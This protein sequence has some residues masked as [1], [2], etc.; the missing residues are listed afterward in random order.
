ME[1]PNPSASSAAYLKQATARLHR[2]V[3]TTLDPAAACRSEAAFV[4]MVDHLAAV[5][6]RT[7]ADARARLDGAGIDWLDRSE[8]RLSA[9]TG[10]AEDRTS[11]RDSSR[12][13]YRSLER[14]EPAAVGS[15]YVLVGSTLGG[16]QL[17]RMAQ[18]SFGHVPMEAF[19]RPDPA[20][21]AFQP[22]MWPEFTAWIDAQGWTRTELARAARGARQTFLAFHPTT[23]SA[24]ESRPQ[25]ASGTHS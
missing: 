3:E 14:S 8:V 17:A 13:A 2:S 22:T 7:G 9:H 20:A 16:V 1:R 12:A 18:A 24:T 19:L 10:G 23:T 25:A 21:G 11:L 15:L 6:R 5:H 4:S